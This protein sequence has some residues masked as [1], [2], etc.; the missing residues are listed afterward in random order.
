MKR[1]VFAFAVV[2]LLTAAPA[3]AQVNRTKAGPTAPTLMAP[4]VTTPANT[5]APTMMAERPAPQQ[6]NVITA[7]S[8]LK[9]TPEMWFYERYMQEYKN[10]KNAVRANA[11]FAAQQRANR[12]AAM[13]WFGFSNSRPR[14]GCDP[15]NVSPPAW[16]SNRPLQPNQWQGTG[17]QPYYVARPEHSEYRSY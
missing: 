4:P 3:W 13:R 6:Q 15:V 11:E 8:D 10:P 9:A 5:T 17:G 1:Y 16:T 12:L 2:M 7:T 14:V